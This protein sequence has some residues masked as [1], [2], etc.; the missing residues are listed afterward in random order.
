VV[1]A[2]DRSPGDIDLAVGARAAGYFH[3]SGVG[4]ALVRANGWDEADLERYRSSPTLV[5]LGGRTAYKHLSRETMIEL[6]RTFPPHWL[7]SSSAVGDAATCASR[8]RAY[9]AA[10]ADGLV[11]HGS[12][13]EHLVSLAAAYAAGSEP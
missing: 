11:L 1:T 10:G 9:L 12:T 5:S 8:L 3:V 6:S 4:D 2:A 13:A 7:P